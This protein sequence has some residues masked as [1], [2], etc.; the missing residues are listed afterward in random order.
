MNSVPVK[1]LLMPIPSLRMS[2]GN[3]EA[4]RLAEE[5]QL[6][7]VDIRIVTL[8]RS[9]H[10]LTSSNVP[11]VHLSSYLADR[12]NARVQYPILLLRFLFY[13][14]ALTR[15][16]EGCKNALILTH[17]STFPLAWLAPHLAWYCFN[18]DV[19]WMFVADGPKRTLLRKL[20]LATSRR[21]SVITTNAYISSLYLQEG[22]QP[23]GQASIWP[24]KSWL[25]HAVSGERDI[26]VVMLLRRGHMKR[27]DLYLEILAQL[28]RVG[29]SSAVVTPDSEIRASVAGLAG[30]CFLRPTDEEIKQLYG[31]SKIFLLLSDTEGFGLPPLESMG[32]GCVPLCR[33]SGGPRCY[34]DGAFV[35]NLMS[36]DAT[37]P[38]ILLRL[39]M[40][41]ADPG[42]LLA[43][44]LEARRR[45]EIGLLSTIAQ[46]KECITR[47]LKILTIDP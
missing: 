32:S 37:I 9:Q 21:A 22:I 3:K 47:L 12:F 44:S 24:P 40:L 29:I 17:F 20:I 4:L 18:Q 28:N 14:L 19:E 2:G 42:G 38:E 23:L 27:L 33:D 30:S 46:R 7:G 6:G 35:G 15:S 11:I 39:Q 16:S 1:T 34:M 13:V 5:L 25:S 45:F 31:R 41:L 43:F 8:W 36:L 10:E 26:D